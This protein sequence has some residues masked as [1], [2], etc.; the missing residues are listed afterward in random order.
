M[1]NQSKLDLIHSILV[2][3]E[4]DLTDE[5]IIHLILDRKMSARESG[6]DSFGAR[7]ADAL[8]RFAGSWT[9][10]ISFMVILIGW[11][12]VNIAMLSRAFD[13]YPFILLNLMLSC[14]AAIQAPLI[15]MSQNRQ[16]Q[17]DRERAV[18]DYRVN[19]KSEIILEDIHNKLDQIVSAQEAMRREM[20]ELKSGVK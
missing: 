16:E 2:D 1:D 12:A 6:D 17:K 15:M 13:P 19:L 9:F 8:A 7:A 5:E 11:I 3:V 10:V 20:D 14:L 18:N 4:D